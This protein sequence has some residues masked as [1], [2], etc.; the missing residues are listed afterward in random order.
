LCDASGLFSE[1]VVSNDVSPNLIFGQSF[2]ADGCDVF[3][4]QQLRCSHPAVTGDDYVLTVDEDGIREAKL[5]D[6]GGNLADLRF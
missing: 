3:H 1:P 2:Q 4:A 5:L 6:A